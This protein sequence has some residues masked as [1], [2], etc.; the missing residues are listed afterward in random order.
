MVSIDCEALCAAVERLI[1]A[2]AAAQ[3]PG[4]ALRCLEQA[5]TVLRKPCDVWTPLK[6]V[7]LE[8]R[9]GAWTIQEPE[10]TEATWDDSLALA[11]GCA[12]WL[13]GGADE[14]IEW[15]GGRAHAVCANLLV[16][17]SQAGA[18]MARGVAPAPEATK[19]ETPVEAFDPFAG[20]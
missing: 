18:S 11:R 5:A 20:L 7:G 8:W 6:A 13:C 3:A 12:C 10:T 15:R 1:R 14:G 9:N 19:V 16:N 17:L 2:T 4:E